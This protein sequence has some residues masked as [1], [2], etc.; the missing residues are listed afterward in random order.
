MGSPL[1]GFGIFTAL[2]LSSAAVTCGPSAS[3]GGPVSWV[4]KKPVPDG[5]KIGG[6]IN[7]TVVYEK[8][9]W[10]VLWL[11]RASIGFSAL[12]THMECLGRSSPNT[13]LE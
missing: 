6:W 3:D 2:W 10:C 8:A 7:S 5:F 13:R 9:K 4:M 11:P 1:L 12:P